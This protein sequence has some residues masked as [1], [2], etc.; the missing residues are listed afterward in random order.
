MNINETDCMMEL[1]LM[2]KTYLLIFIYIF[3]V[4]I[5]STVLCQEFCMYWWAGRLSI[6]PPC[7]SHYTGETV[8]RHMKK[9]ITNMFKVEIETSWEIIQLSYL[10]TTPN[11]FKLNLCGEETFKSLKKN[12]PEG[13]QSFWG[14]AAFIIQSDVR[15]AIVAKA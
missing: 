4:P 6:C 10:W 2:F 13:I 14:R 3:W 8:N 1:A 12:H 7:S 9:Y 5:I 11:T 15:K